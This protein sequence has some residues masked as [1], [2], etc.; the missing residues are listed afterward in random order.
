MNEAASVLQIE[1]GAGDDV[2][3]QERLT[4]ELRDKLAALDGI[5]V[6][7]G[8]SAGPSG[9]G[10]KG[11]VETVLTLIATIT[12]L[13]RPA[14]QVLVTA[15]QE[16]CVRDSRRV[17]H[18]KDGDRSLEIKGDPTDAQQRAIEEFLRRFDDRDESSAQ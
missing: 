17:V 12:A 3:R 11:T 18:L 16:W 7:F 6:A 8:A 10:R 13:G 2:L 9:E 1:V 15:I 4:R 14:A 5:D